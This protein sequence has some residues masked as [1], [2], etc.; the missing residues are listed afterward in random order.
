M[1]PRF[2]DPNSDVYLA[3]AEA[4]LALYDPKESATRIAINEAVTAIV[5]GSA[6]I[7]IAKGLNKLIQ[8]GATFSQSADLEYPVLRHDLFQ[9][10]VQQIASSDSF[11]EFTQQ[12]HSDPSF[13]GFMDDI[14]GDHPQNERLISCRE[15]TA[16][17]LLLRYNCSLVQSLL[18]QCK[19]VSVTI[20]KGDMAQMRRLFK[21]LKFF[22]LLADISE[23]EKGTIALEIS[24]PATLF[25][26]ST[27]YGLQLA[28]FFPAIPLVEEWSISA[29]IH[30]KNRPF[31]LELDEKSDLQSHYKT[32]SA[33][34][35][36]EVQLFYTYFKQKVADWKISE[37]T[38]WIKTKGG[39]LIFPDF[40][41]RHKSGKVLH[42]E[43]FHRW[44]QG[45]L[46]D[47]L[48][49][50][51][52]YTKDNLLIGVERAVEKKMENA[53]SQSDFFQENG[54]A[55]RE[56][57]ALSAVKKLLASKLL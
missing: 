41:F 7:K 44:H 18:L 42:L 5:N 45:Q 8:D 9:K 32:F 40:S 34:I 15:F 30:L 36:K 2:I 12:M 43:L 29:E 19:S 24:G 6:D 14:Y 16:H 51:E 39:A 11:E 46:Q 4:L 53:L 23:P 49:F 26:S 31:T 33:Y 52:S 47:R 37:A 1:I 27:K 56:F 57:P 38:P 54:F 22:R 25:E 28:S 35:P 3:M 20:K 55:F 10:S 13:A 17:S 48:H 50:L 21:Y